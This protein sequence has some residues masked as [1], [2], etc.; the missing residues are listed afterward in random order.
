MKWWSAKKQIYLLLPFS[1][2]SWF[3]PFY[4][5]F[6]VSRIKKQPNCWIS[7][8]RPLPTLTER[9]WRTHKNRYI[10]VSCN[11]FFSSTA[12]IQSILPLISPRFCFG[13][14][15]LLR[16]SFSGPIFLHTH[17]VS[18]L[19]FCCSISRMFECFGINQFLPIILI[20]LSYIISKLFTKLISPL[21][22]CIKSAA[23]GFWHH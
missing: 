5:T 14:I 16:L 10:F 4:T 22:Y 11:L 20:K 15:S 2:S 23:H 8:F 19:T 9:H 3:S 17:F 13:T 21:H 1:E 12:L 7:S 6:E 18:F